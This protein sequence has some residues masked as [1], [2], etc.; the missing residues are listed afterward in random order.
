MN[1]DFVI[2]NTEFESELERIKFKHALMDEVASDYFCMLEAVER[3]FIK[4][5]GEFN[6]QE[7]DRLTVDLL[8]VVELKKMTGALE[9]MDFNA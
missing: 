7:V 1:L 8:K 3:N 5:C 6:R 4:E 9:G 2:N